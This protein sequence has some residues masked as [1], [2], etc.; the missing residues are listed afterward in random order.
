MP[1]RRSIFAT[2]VAGAIAGAGVV[3]TSFA[4]PQDFLELAPGVSASPPQ[5]EQIA[6]NRLWEL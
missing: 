2:V 1:G 6:D 4:L 5:V 3:A